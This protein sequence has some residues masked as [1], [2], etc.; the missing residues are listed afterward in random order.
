VTVVP[1]TLSQG[2][3]PEQTAGPQVPPHASDEAHPLGS[4]L[5]AYPYDGVSATQ[6]PPLQWRPAPH[7]GS[8]SQEKHAP[9]VVYVRVQISPATQVLSPQVV[10]AASLL[11]SAMALSTR[12]VSAAALST[13]LVSEPP[14]S[15][16]AES[17]GAGPSVV[18]APQPHST[19]ARAVAISEERNMGTS[20]PSGP[21]PT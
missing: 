17:V 13:T 15:A 11:V 8:L 12:A 2:H 20:I 9:P 14:E 19:E 3:P 16:T 18:V 4:D 10:P 21:F 1:L 5:H 7:V 6:H